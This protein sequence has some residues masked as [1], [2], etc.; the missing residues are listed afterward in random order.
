MSHFAKVTAIEYVLPDTLL[1]NEDLARDFPEW[2]V[3]KICGEG[4]FDGLLKKKLIEIL[5]LAFVRGLSIDNAV[6]IID[7]T[8]NLSDHTFKTIMTRIG[9]DSKYVFLGDTEQV[10]K[11]KKNESCLNKV[12]DIF[13]DSN[14]VGTVEFTDEDCVRNPIIPKILEALRTRGM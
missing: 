3:D 2:N 12:V 5:P 4:A 7:E 14:I 9:T 1:S 13:K 11:K 10:D 6:V 8:Q